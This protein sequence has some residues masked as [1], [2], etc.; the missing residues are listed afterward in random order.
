MDGYFKHLEATQKFMNMQ[1]LFDKQVE[2]NTELLDIS[3]EIESLP[4]IPDNINDWTSSIQDCNPDKKFTLSDFKRMFK[5]NKKYNVL[6]EER[7]KNAQKIKV[8]VIDNL[9]DRIKD[10][11]D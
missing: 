10:L 2:I 4:E 7:D 8:L 3:E 5:I 9:L 11:L 1:K 6:L